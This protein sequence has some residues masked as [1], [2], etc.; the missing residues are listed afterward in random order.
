M[1]NPFQSVSNLLDKF[2]RGSVSR[3]ELRRFAFASLA[4]ATGISYSALRNAQA[5]TAPPAPTKQVAIF[6][7]DGSK[8]PRAE[9]GKATI[10]TAEEI[11]KKYVDDPNFS[12]QDHLEWAPP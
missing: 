12:V 6:A 8:F 4:V 3:R 2:E 7:I 10:W 11:K 1:E 5:Q 9:N